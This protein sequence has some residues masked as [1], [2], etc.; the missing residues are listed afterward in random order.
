MAASPS[1][2]LGAYAALA[3]AAAL[4]AGNAIASR[5]AIGVVSPMV[6]LTLRMAVVL[7]ILAV[8]VRRTLP[9][10][11]PVLRERK[12]YLALCGLF[13]FTG[14]TGLMYWAAN[15][16]TAVNLTIL[17]GSIPVWVLLGM[18]IV[19]GVPVRGIEMLGVAITLAG[20]AVLASGGDIGQLLRL[21]VNAGDLAML[22]ACLF[23]AIYSVA[24]H[25]RPAV[26]G[27]AFFALVSVA[28][29]LGSLPLLGLEAA[30]GAPVWP[31][32]LP[33]L[34]I[35]VYVGVF[36]SLVAQIFFMRGVEAIGPGRA[37]L[38]VNLVPVFGAALGTLLLGERFGL[39]EALALALV[40]GGILTAESGRMTAGSK[41]QT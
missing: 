36:P 23:W 33:A 15:H 21:S 40:V 6:L 24:L 17:Q 39:V 12:A 20:V 22:V 41:P 1:A 31:A 26:D 10:A 9:E 7:V 14:F 38:F 8:V 27:L 28:A 30:G 32:S 3:F 34:A 4:W 5:Y 19:F 11:W 13:G 35:I 25:R 2:T 18:R 16:T 29:F 37:G